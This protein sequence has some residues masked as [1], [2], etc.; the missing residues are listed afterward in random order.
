MTKTS[1][2]KPW[3]ILLTEFIIL[4]DLFSNKVSS[5]QTNG[6]DKYMIF[7]VQFRNGRNKTTYLLSW[8]KI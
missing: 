2:N 6:H 8:T 5:S 7:N 4:Q 1:F 3:Q